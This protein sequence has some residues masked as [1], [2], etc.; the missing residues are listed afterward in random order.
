M[1]YRSR[2]GLLAPLDGFEV[3]VGV[4]GRGSGW[5]I[6]ALAVRVYAGLLLSAL[7]VCSC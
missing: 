5:Q 6:P 4:G 7:V 1:R 3:V 2:W